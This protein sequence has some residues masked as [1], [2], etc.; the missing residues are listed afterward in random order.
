MKIAFATLGCK[1]NRADTTAIREALPDEVELVSFSQVADIYV[2]NTCTVTATADRQSRQLVHRAHRRNPAAEVIVTG[3]LAELNPA[4]LRKL[5][6]VVAV[7]PNAAKPRLAETIAA[8]LGLHR[9]SWASISGRPEPRYVPHEVTRQ[10]LKIQDGCDG[11]CTYCTVAAARGRP[12]S[13]PPDHVLADL[14]S[15]GRQG[16]PE[17]VLAGIDL[18]SYGR[19]LKPPSSLA[20]LL[21]RV[22]RERPVWRVRLSSIE[23]LQLTDAVIEQLQRGS[24]AICRHLHLPLQSGA[25]PVLARMRRPYDAE[26]YASRVR[27]VKTRIPDLAIGV[28]VIAGF[29]GETDADHR[30]TLELLGD[31]RVSYL[32][33]FPF[34]A[35]PSTPAAALPHPVERRVI[36]D[37]ARALRA[38]GATLWRDFRRAQQ[39]REVS[40]VVS[41][42]RRQQRLL[43]VSDQAIRVVLDGPARLPGTVARVELCELTTDGMAGR[44]V[45]EEVLQ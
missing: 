24:G 42:R 37:R 6:G 36:R 23:I 35:R 25:D 45:T 30:C 7:E 14:Y 4:P 10:P 17:V 43:A 33:V 20:A 13:E 40:V 27:A 41:A 28:D 5:S 3:C 32:H 39:G 8:R 18:G 21:T 22:R 1:V 29:P 31:L 38:L 16:C 15:L 2:I 44:L 9:L 26:T 11:G 19:D 12:V 34:S